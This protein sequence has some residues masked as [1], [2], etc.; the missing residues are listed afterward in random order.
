[1]QAFDMAAVE[2]MAWVVLDT[3]DVKEVAD[4]SMYTDIQVQQEADFGLTVGFFVGMNMEEADFGLTTGFL[5][6]MVVAA[7][8]FAKTPQTTDYLPI[9]GCV[10]LQ[11]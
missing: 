11:A 6:Y 10:F 5:G 8:I 4:D 9:A 1:M 2:C 3:S 7:E